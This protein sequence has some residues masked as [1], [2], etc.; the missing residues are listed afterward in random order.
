MS[1][2]NFDVTGGTPGVMGGWGGYGGAGAAFAGAL[3]GGV[4]GDALFPGYGGRG[5]HG[6]GWDGGEGVVQINAG[7]H[8]GSNIG[9]WELFKE[10]SDTRREVAIN[11]YLMENGL[12]QQTIANNASLQ[13]LMMEIGRVGHGIDRDVLISRFDNALQLA[14]ISREMAECC[15]KQ[16][17]ATTVMGFETQLRDQAMHNANMLEHRNTQC[18]IKDT[19]KDAIIRELTRENAALDRRLNTAEIVSTITSTLQPPRPV[20][21]YIQANPY[22]N[23]M[24]TVRCAPECNPRPNWFDNCGR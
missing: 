12:L 22:E 11:P 16:L 20:P 5:G 18:L 19:E 14:G 8:H 4:I 3:V 21:A 2:Q 1:W 24:P 15:C 9:Q 23:Y 17:M 13:N 7:G 10:M 6:R